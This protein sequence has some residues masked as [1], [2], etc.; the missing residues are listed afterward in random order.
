[1]TPG[2]ELSALQMLTLSNDNAT[3]MGAE[4]GRRL[5]ARAVPMVESLALGRLKAQLKLIVLA[6]TVHTFRQ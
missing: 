5:V 1:M 6:T 2:V 3:C 4:P